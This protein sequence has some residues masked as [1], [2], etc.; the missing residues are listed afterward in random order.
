[1][2]NVDKFMNMMTVTPAKKTATKMA[3]MI[4]M[5]TMAMVMVKM[6]MMVKMTVM[7]ALNDDGGYGG[8]DQ[9]MRTTL[10]NKRIGKVKRV[11]SSRLRRLKCMIH[12]MVI[13]FFGSVCRSSNL[14]SCPEKLSSSTAHRHIS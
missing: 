2:P 11:S 7:R 1:M 3:T 6:M 4:L 10:V 9:N 13:A 5:A 12:Q 8:V 14:V